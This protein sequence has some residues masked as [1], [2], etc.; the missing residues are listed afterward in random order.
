MSVGDARSTPCMV[1]FFTVSARRNL[2][3]MPV[4]RGLPANEYWT[5][6][7]LAR[8]IDPV[9]A[10]ARA[11]RARLGSNGVKEPRLRVKVT[12]GFLGVA[13]LATCAGS[14]PTPLLIGVLLGI[15]LIQELPRALLARLSGRSAEVRIDAVGGQTE[16]SGRPTSNGFDVGLATVGSLVSLLVA[17]VCLF[18][19][20]RM[21]HGPVAS[22]LSQAGR[23]Q[24]VWGA[25]HLLPFAPF[26]LGALFASHL[27]TTARVKHAVASLLMALVV[28]ATLVDEMGSP[29]VFV[30][31]LLLV[32]ACC[33]N[34]MRSVAAARDAKLGAEQE[35]RKIEALTLAGHTRIA[36]RLAEALLGRARSAALKARVGRAL[37]WAAIGEGDAAQAQS[38]L[39]WLP[40]T[41]VDLHLLC[42]FLATAGRTAEAVELLEIAGRHGQRSAESVKLLADLYYRERRFE[43]VAALA[44]NANELL[45]PDE[46]ERIA[47]ALA[48]AEL[49]GKEKPP[50]SAAQVGAAQVLLPFTR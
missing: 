30:A 20:T 27:G 4:A 26:K 41:A 14:Q 11:V 17:A 43:Q 48:H 36:I 21:A 40:E 6:S 47:R 38:A 13:A 16:V 33:R 37:V 24:A 50:A 5:M 10:L 44:A 18:G 35:L 39:F 2:D 42:S 22:W 1:K 12:L 46:L 19:A 3:E 23:L 34:L 29:L 8:S 31:M 15:A 25:A 9:P 45:S 7:S 28:V 32:S 49:A